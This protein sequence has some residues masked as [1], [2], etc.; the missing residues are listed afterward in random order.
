[1]KDKKFLVMVILGVVWLALLI[2]MFTGEYRV[3]PRIEY[4]VT[5]LCVGWF[6]YWTLTTIFGSSETVKPTDTT[7]DNG[8]SEN[9]PKS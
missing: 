6:A 2:G 7:K 5:F 1:M 4:L 9:T 8:K 3:N